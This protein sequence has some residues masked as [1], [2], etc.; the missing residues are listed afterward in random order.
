MCVEEV[1]GAHSLAHDLRR[2]VDHVGVA[3]A[4]PVHHVGHL[5]PTLQLVALYLNGKDRDRRGL[6][7]RE[8]RLG[9]A[10]QRAL[11]QVFEQKAIPRA[12][13]LL[14]LRGQR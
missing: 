10:D 5:H 6:H 3:H 1:Q 8:N 7:I 4:P 12:A 11:G 9:H 13:K 14:Q 2:D